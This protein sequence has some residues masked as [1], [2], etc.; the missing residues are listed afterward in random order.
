M[1]N[2]PNPRPAL[3]AP[4]MLQCVASGSQSPCWWSVRR[5]PNPNLRST[6]SQQRSASYLR[7]QPGFLG[8]DLRHDLQIRR[9]RY[10]ILRCHPQRSGC[11]PERGKFGVFAHGCDIVFHVL[12]KGG[13]LSQGC[14]TREGISEAAPEAV[15]QTG[16]C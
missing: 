9:L 3:A 15:R 5:D 10:S 8:N 7:L 14:I 2:P 11:V 4:K 1:R 16:G 13:G 12:S 6:S